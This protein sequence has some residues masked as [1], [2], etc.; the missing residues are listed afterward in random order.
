M[1]QTPPLLLQALAGPAPVGRP[2]QGHS[3]A[4][5][6]LLLACAA[7]CTCRPS[8]IDDVHTAGSP[9]PPPAAGTNPSFRAVKERRR[10]YVRLLSQVPLHGSCRRG[11]E[12]LVWSC[13]LPR[14]EHAVD[15]S[16]V[17]V[18]AQCCARTA[19]WRRSD[20]CGRCWAPWRR[21]RSRRSRCAR[22]TIRTGTRSTRRWRR[23]SAAR[24]RRSRAPPWPSA[25]RSAPRT[26]SRP[27]RSRR[28]RPT[29]CATDSR[30][31]TG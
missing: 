16:A 28:S 13:A 4:P 25:P 9:R 6:P 7:L 31:C 26:R 10:P 17:G 5:L 19:A 12:A 8:S 11:G 3:P 23:T 30:S 2:M 20:G 27:P 18:R 15:E 24:A 14:T 29:S 1:A 22:R 21:R